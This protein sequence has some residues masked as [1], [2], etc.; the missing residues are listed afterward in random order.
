MPST[1]RFAFVIASQGEELL[2]DDR[3]DADGPIRRRRRRRLYRDDKL[4]FVLEIDDETDEDFLS[5]LLDKQLP[6]GIRLC[7]TKHM[8]DF[9]LGGGGEIS[10]ET[11]GPLI[12]AMLRYT[13]NHPTTRGTRSNLLFSSLCQE[14]LAQLCDR[15][16]HLA[17]LVVVGL[18][19]QVNLTPDD[20]VEIIGTQT[21][22]QECVSG[23]AALTPQKLVFISRRYRK[24]RS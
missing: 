2:Q 24:C 14:L 15:I 11:S 4:P 8:P 22:C 20:Q 13:W 16:K 9:G 5:V 19:T 21:Q 10:E 1:Y 17:P 18:R 12:V 23:K 6:E 7:T 3:I